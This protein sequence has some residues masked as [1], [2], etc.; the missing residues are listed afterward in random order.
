MAV[1]SQ[2]A[3]DRGRRGTQTWQG[4]FAVPHLLPAPDTKA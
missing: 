4:G 2:T 3:K 1:I